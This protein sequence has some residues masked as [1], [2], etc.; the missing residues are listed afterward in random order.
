[1]IVY[2]GT[3]SER[4][5]FFRQ[6]TNSIFHTGGID[7]K[8]PHHANAIAQSEAHQ[9]SDYLGQLFSSQWSFDRCRMQDVE[10][11]EECCYYQASPRKTLVATNTTSFSTSFLVFDTRLQRSWYGTCSKPRTIAQRILSQRQ[12]SFTTHEST[13][14]LAHFHEIGRSRFGYERTILFIQT[15]NSQGI[16]RFDRYT[17]SYGTSTSID[18]G[19]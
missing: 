9:D 16:V 2:S 4:C 6:A 10:F 12:N 15:S 8:F 1:M 13:E 17:H 3:Y 7:L 19:H 5:F 18:I 11:V 14:S